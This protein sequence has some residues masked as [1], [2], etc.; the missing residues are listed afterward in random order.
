MKTSKL[1]MC[2]TD[3]DNNNN[4]NVSSHGRNIFSWHTR[5]GNFGF[6]HFQWLDRTGIIGNLGIK[7]GSITV[8]PPIVLFANLVNNSALPNKI[9]H[10]EPWW[11][12][13]QSQPS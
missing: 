4:N 1:L 3:N 5:R 11:G 8:N 13:H 7:F 9:L 6:Y 12:I 10:R 2:V